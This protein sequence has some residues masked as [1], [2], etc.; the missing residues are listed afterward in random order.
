MYLVLTTSCPTLILSRN[1]R[2][3][4]DCFFSK[5]CTFLE[6]CLHIC[7][8]V[9]DINLSPETAKCSGSKLICSHRYIVVITPSRSA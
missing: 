5:N 2:R 9:E 8:K 6:Y 4:K 7:Y 3:K 1:G